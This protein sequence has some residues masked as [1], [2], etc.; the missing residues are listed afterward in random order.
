MLTKSSPKDTSSNLVIFVRDIRCTRKIERVYM[1]SEV[2]D[3][4]K[5]NTC[6]RPGSTTFI[7]QS[8]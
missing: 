2:N 3:H 6:I 8:K 5:G 4:A 1:E 7:T